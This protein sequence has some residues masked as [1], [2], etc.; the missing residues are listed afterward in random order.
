MRRQ[1]GFAKLV[2]PNRL[3]MFNLL[4]L[5]DSGIPRVFRFLRNDFPVV[6]G[7]W[8]RYINKRRCK[9]GFPNKEAA[10]RLEIFDLKNSCI[11]ELN[12]IYYKSC[13]C[14]RDIEAA[15]KKKL[16]FEN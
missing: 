8:M 7:C 12:V 1:T 3:K 10:I 14:E 16:I 15:M 2:L 13:C 4:R 5:V 6:F 9:R 11:D